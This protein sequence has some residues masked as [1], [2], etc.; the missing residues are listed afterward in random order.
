MCDLK[1]I[2]FRQ[3]VEN[4]EALKSQ[5]QEILSPFFN[6][7]MIKCWKTMIYSLEILEWQKDKIWEVLNDDFEI[8]E[9]NKLIQGG[10]I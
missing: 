6:A 4:S 7:K 9:L 3:F 10:K 8:E 1:K 5:Y 2:T